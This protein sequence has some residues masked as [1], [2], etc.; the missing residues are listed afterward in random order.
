MFLD[1]FAIFVFFCLQDKMM[2][3]AS[4]LRFSFFLF[5]FNINK[6]PKR[7]RRDLIQFLGF[8]FASFR[9]NLLQ[10]T[11]FANVTYTDMYTAW[12]FD[13]F[14]GSWFALLCLQI[15]LTTCFLLLHLPQCFVTFPSTV[16][17][18]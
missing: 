4:S 16:H 2:L 17:I 5:K 14:S 1:P 10:F 13:I 9:R 6:H 12:F 11:G 18:V 3:L 8:F 15:R 7:R